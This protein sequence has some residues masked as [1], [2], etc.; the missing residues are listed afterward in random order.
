MLVSVQRCLRFC[1]YVCVSAEGLLSSSFPP[2]RCV[3]Y[4]GGQWLIV[5]PPP[6]NHSVQTPFGGRGGGAGEATQLN[7]HLFQSQRFIGQ[8]EAGW[9]PQSHHSRPLGPFFYG[10]QECIFLL[11]RHEYMMARSLNALCSSGA[12][13]QLGLRWRTWLGA[14]SA[15]PAL[16]S[17][18]CLPGA[19]PKRQTQ[20]RRYPPW[21]S[22]GARRARSLL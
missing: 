15:L 17:F 1:V 20:P 4:T 5:S 2:R 19:H 18:G 22:G 6:D 10:C 12:W 13:Y 9:Q 11:P 8:G 3:F 7:L 21:Q 16:P 14:N